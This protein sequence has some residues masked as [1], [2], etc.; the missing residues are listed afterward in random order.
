MSLSHPVVV[1]SIA[2]VVWIIASMVSAVA[3]GPYIA[4]LV[5]VVGSILIYL[6]LAL[7]LRSKSAE[8]FYVA[9]RR[10]PALVNGA[11]TAADWE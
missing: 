10:I 8:A 1:T 7:T 5:L 11:A 2:I 6:T 9:E 4:S 3:A